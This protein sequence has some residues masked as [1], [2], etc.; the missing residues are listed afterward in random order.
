MDAFDDKNKMI[1][2][3]HFPVKS[4][5]AALQIFIGEILHDKIFGKWHTLVSFSYS[6]HTTKFSRHEFGPTTERKSQL[7]TNMKFLLLQKENALR[8]DKLFNEKY[9]IDTIYKVFYN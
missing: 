8:L 9:V 6:A 1:L 3:L 5:E 2:K 4:L 7:L